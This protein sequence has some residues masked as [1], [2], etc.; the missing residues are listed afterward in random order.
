M[1]DDT[2]AAAPVTLDTIRQKYPQ[3]KDVDDETLARGLHEKFYSQLPFNDFAAKVGYK[4]AQQTD[5]SPTPETPGA[6]T[7]IGHAASGLIAAP[8]AQG[9]GTAVGVAKNVGHMISGAPYEDPRDT[10]RQYAAPFQFNDP[11]PAPDV[12]EQARRALPKVGDIPAVKKA[13]E[14]PAGQFVGD[15]A[16]PVADIAGGVGAAGGVLKAV[17]AAGGAL[18]AGINAVNKPNAAQAAT[19][20][21][22]PQITRMRA[23]GFKIAGSDSYAASNAATPGDNV[24][25]H[26]PTSTAPD[27]MHTIQRDN[28]ALATQKM[29]ED[30]KLHNTRA[31]NPDEIKARLDKEGTVYD[32]MGQA[33][34]KGRTPTANLDHDLSTAAPSAADPAA[35]TANAKLVDNYRDHFKTS[36]FDGPD[37]IQMVKDLRN[38]AHVGMASNDVNAQSLGRTKLGIANAIENEMMRQLPA[39]A[40][41]LKTAF[42]EARMQYAKL[43]ELES[44]TEGGQVSPLKVLQLKRSGAPLSGS[45]DAVANAADVAPE[46]M[47]R[48]AGTPDIL[49]Y[50]PTHTGVIRDAVNVGKR[51]AHKLPGND[52]TTE[53]YQEAHYGPK[54]GT[55]ATPPSSS[56]PKVSELPPPVDLKPPPGN[57]RSGTQTQMP[58][59]P[60]PAAPPAFELSHPEGTA[61][62]PGQRPLG[63]NGQPGNQMVPAE[64]DRQALARVRAMTPTERAAAEGPPV[65]HDKLDTTVKSRKGRPLGQAFNRE[66]E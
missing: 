60:G 17:G 45:A 47:K 42:P 38:E 50:A 58:L 40:Q 49:P 24:A 54:G 9:V 27:T 33:V 37:G 61:F 11:E 56:A 31:V 65:Y 5:Q 4:P 14:S 63:R 52:P 12:K 20:K 28:Q 34:G 39:S 25:L 41:E 55:A 13:V 66:R 35:S 29:A 15:V 7:Q 23:D 10:G 48:A 22:T 18:D 62:E 19:L 26:G 51:M 16:G 2:Q 1:A 59:P 57:A 36:G 32:Q 46:S 43:K 21:S 64:W 30:V 44:V 53:A 6:L 8:I 3:Y